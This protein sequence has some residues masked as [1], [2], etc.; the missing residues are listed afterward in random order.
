MIIA[1]LGAGWYPN[2]SLKWKDARKLLDYG[3][4]N[5]EYQQLGKDEWHFEEIPVID[6][7]EKT[8]EITTD[9]KTFSYLL[10]K[11]E[12]SQCK[13]ECAEQLQAPVEKKTV[14]G[15]ITY[16]LNGKIIEQFQV[17]TAGDVEKS[18]FWNRV[19]KW[20]RSIQDFVGILINK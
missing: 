9:A 16:E 2:K 13:V 20:L 18:T 19:K 17:Y 7:M 10:G 14:V 12:V 6:G 11:G 5:F 1:L 3:F 8:V 15:T 4:E